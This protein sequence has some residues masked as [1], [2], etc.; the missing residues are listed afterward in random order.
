MTHTWH[1]KFSVVV[2]LGAWQNSCVSPLCGQ[3]FNLG[4]Q[5]SSF[6]SSQR[7]LVYLRRNQVGRE[8]VSIIIDWKRRDGQPLSSI[9][10]D[11]VMER[12]RM[13]SFRFE[14]D[15]CVLIAC[16]V[17]NSLRIRV[18]CVDYRSSLLFVILVLSLNNETTDRRFRNACVMNAD[19]GGVVARN[20]NISNRG[21]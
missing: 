15:V 19:I 5:W 11:N 1:S 12:T 8:S 20:K 6:F 18:I 10:V 21:A 2:R 7:L 9:G 16:P 4:Q 13:C 14:F 3:N 17:E